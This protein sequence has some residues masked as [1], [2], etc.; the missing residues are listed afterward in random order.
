[1]GPP[2]VVLQG[3]V[4]ELLE[5]IVSRGEIDK[6]LLDFIEG[7]L[8]QK[9]FVVVQLGQLELQNKLLHALHTVIFAES[10]VDERPLTGPE[11]EEPSALGD[12]LSGS[13]PRV[14]SPLLIQTILDALSLPSNRP[15]LQHW[16]DFVSTAT[17][18]LQLPPA[19]LA[20]PL[21]E[22]IGRQV[23]G[24]LADLERIAAIRLARTGDLRSRTTDTELIM[25][26]NAFERL[27]LIGL[28]R[29]AGVPMLSDDPMPSS[30]KSVVEPS[31]G[32]LGLVS[33]VFSSE[34]TT[35]PSAEVP[36]VSI[37]AICSL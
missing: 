12:D 8:V 10:A 31:A 29:F 33:G 1:M 37:F 5:A 18:H 9:L 27:V 19:Q 13:A 24:L 30:E 3:T 26:L 14:I 6:R 32:L 23:R 15:V 36:L 7:A 34:G 21:V 17:P 35:T 22:C 28:A 4:V 25:F 16:L 11:G 20:V 2:N